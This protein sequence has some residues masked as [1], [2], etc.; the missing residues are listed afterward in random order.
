MRKWMRGFSPVGGEAQGFDDALA[1]SFLVFSFG[2]IGITTRASRMR[3]EI[4][5]LAFGHDYTSAAGLRS[6][7][8]TTPL[9]LV[10]SENSLIFLQSP[11]RSARVSERTCFVCAT[12]R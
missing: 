10:F 12:E 2:P 1:A 11:A 3:R 8:R 5:V 7:D 4:V 9:G 6:R